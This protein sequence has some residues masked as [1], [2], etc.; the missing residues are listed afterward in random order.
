MAKK[1]KKRQQKKNIKNTQNKKM[2]SKG[3]SPKQIKQMTPPER[4]KT[5]KKIEANE[6]KQLRREENKKFLKKH[7]ITGNYTINGV[8]YTPSKMLDLGEEKLNLIL[9]EARKQKRRERDYRIEQAKIK[10]LTD[11]GF[12][13]E[14]ASKYKRRNKDIISNLIFLGDRNVYKAKA[15]LS[16]RWA[17]VTGESQMGLAVTD[18]SHYST[19]EMIEEIRMFKTTIKKDGSGDFKGVPKIITHE[20]K[21]QLN[22]QILDSFESGYNEKMVTE[23]Q[24]IMY[25]NEWT[26]RGYANMMLSVLS[27]T[28]DNLKLSSYDEFEDY[29]RNY[30]P[31][32]YKQIF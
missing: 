6:R 2:M 1:P 15:F 18:Y 29:A 5:V 7:N 32:I 27:R 13:L 11:A 30:L 26:L 17:D 9:D 3:L 19:E 14:Q 4:K 12:D 20:D 23:G 10:Q 24:Q 16:V 8:K 31:E 25:S 22:N 21:K 28:S